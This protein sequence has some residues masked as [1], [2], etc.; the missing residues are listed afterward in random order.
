M[1]KCYFSVNK[2]PQ[3]CNTEK[4]QKRG[5]GVERERKKISSSKDPLIHINDTLPGELYYKIRLESGRE[6]WSFD[7]RESEYRQ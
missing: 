5:D 2:Y 1:M 3:Y 6:K 7:I 4:G